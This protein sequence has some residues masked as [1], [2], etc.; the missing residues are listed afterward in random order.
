MFPRLLPVP[1]KNSLPQLGNTTTFPPLDLYAV[2]QELR[3]LQARVAYSEARTAQLEERLA[4][5]DARFAQLKSQ[6]AGPEWI[7]PL[8]AAEALC[9]SKSTITRLCQS[10]VIES[11]KGARAVRIRAA[12]V[13]GYNASLPAP[14]RGVELALERMLNKRK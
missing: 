6:P 14:R 13:R 2:Y 12:S 8:Q 1:L 5:A 7:T 10:G 11:V 4:H 3:Q 9:C